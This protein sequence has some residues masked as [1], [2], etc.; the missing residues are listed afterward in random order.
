MQKTLN[1]DKEKLKFAIKGRNAHIEHCKGN[2]E[3]WAEELLQI[4]R[5]ANN[6]EVKLKN[7]MTNHETTR[8]SHIALQRELEDIDK[9]NCLTLLERVM[10]VLPENEQIM[11][12]QDT[13]R[14]IREG[15]ESLKEIHEDMPEQRSESGEQ[16]ER[17][18]PNETITAADRENVLINSLLDHFNKFDQSQ[19]RFV[20][21]NSAGALS[22]RG[23]QTTLWL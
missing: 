1:K 10:E 20:S 19:F 13:V 21:S 16:E 7:S 4:R 8:N 18:E 6:S 14:N 12:N 23:T 2:N 9:N 5:D 3:R 15:L 11:F 22:G 17:E